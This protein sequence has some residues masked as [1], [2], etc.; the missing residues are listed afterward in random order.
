MSD[1]QHYT[2]ILLNNVF[3]SSNYID[4]HNPPHQHPIKL[5]GLAAESMC[6]VEHLA[7]II[8]QYNVGPNQC[9]ML[10]TPTLILY[11]VYSP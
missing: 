2:L 7:L 8:C 1:K 3:I 10:I 4:C 6:L 11:T 9:F 5:I